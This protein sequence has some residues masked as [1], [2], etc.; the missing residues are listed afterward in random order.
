[1]YLMGIC[2]GKGEYRYYFVIYTY[3]H[4]VGVGA[5]FWRRGAQPG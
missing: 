3:H 1:M 2:K 4:S 5:M